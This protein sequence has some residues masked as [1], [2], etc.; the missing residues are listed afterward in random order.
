MN[1]KIEDFYEYF[2]NVNDSIAINQANYDY[3]YLMRGYAYSRKG[4]YALA[5]A[6]YDE[7]LRLN[8]HNKMRERL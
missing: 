5:K 6:D 1:Q 8:P 2:N 7:A 4:D 3:A